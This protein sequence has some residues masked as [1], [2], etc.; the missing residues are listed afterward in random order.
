MLLL[1][2]LP[3]CAAIF[4]FHNFPFSHFTHSIY[5]LY[6]LHTHMEGKLCAENC[7][8]QPGSAVHCDMTNHLKIFH[9]T[10]TTAATTTTATTFSI[11]IPYSLS[12]SLCLS[13][14]LSLCLALGL[15][16]IFKHFVCLPTNFHNLP[17]ASFCV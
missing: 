5:R 16:E 7:P 1:L 8:L 9:G 11:S 12:P 14:S 13:F 4:H 15:A 3:D 2:Q 6:L 17:T 10:A